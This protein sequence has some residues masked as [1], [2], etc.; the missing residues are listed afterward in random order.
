MPGLKRSPKDT[1]GEEDEVQEC[2]YL[3]DIRQ[4]QDVGEDVEAWGLQ[5]RADS[6]GQCWARQ[7]QEL[8]HLHLTPR[9]T[10][11]QKLSRLDK[12]NKER[13]MRMRMSR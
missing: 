3:S 7:G 1:R 2:V 11:D 6:L 8:L 5:Q 4:L 9:E 10:G 12:S 13:H